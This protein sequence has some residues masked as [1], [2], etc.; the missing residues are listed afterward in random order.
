[1]AADIFTK[2]FSNPHAWDAACSMV[3]ICLPHAVQALADRNG[4]PPTATEGGENAD[5]GKSTKMGQVHGPAT[6]Q[7]KLGSA[8]SG[9]MAQSMKK[10][11]VGRL[12]MMT[13]TS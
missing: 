13:Q 7:R 4:M 11:F 9:Q 12:M 1:M 2:A 10:S 6:I 3:N 5:C 8:L